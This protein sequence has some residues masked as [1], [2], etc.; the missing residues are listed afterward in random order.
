MR[1]H[2]AL[3]WDD[4]SGDR[5]RGAPVPPASRKSMRDRVG[6]GFH[7]PI[8]LR[9]PL[10]YL[11]PKAAEGLSYRSQIRELHLRVIA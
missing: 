5:T 10:S 3:F 7:P 4:C 11:S 9:L 2:D 8:E 1:G 6:L